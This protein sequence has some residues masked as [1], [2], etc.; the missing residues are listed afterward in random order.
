MSLFCILCFG[1]L[2]ENQINIVTLLFILADVV[3]KLQTFYI[4]PFLFQ[5]YPH[6]KVNRS[7][8]NIEM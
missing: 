6:K 4:P 3:V 7:R 1:T 2:A 5:C 8:F